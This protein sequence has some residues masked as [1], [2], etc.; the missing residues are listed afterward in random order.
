MIIDELSQRCK[1]RFVNFK[2][3]RKKLQQ[4]IHEDNDKENSR[5]YYKGLLSCLN[6]EFDPLVLGGH[7]EVIVFLAVH[8]EGAETDNGRILEG[9]ED[10]SV[11]VESIVQIVDDLEKVHEF[12]SR[13]FVG[14]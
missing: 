13:H 10:R 8:E 12:D 3:A 7:L 9:A 6:F 2:K 4:T 5:E 11:S 1:C 14:P